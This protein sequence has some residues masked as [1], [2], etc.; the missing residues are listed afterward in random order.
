MYEINRK[1]LDT[2]KRKIFDNYE[3]MLK[4]RK[5]TIE[6]DNGGSHT[7]DIYK[8]EEVTIKAH[9]TGDGDEYW[10]ENQPLP[11][12]ANKELDCVFEEA[13]SYLRKEKEQDTLSKIKR[14]LGG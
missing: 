8:L 9:F 2:L 6:R 1:E 11:D 14:L 3:D 13:M 10:L 12:Y 4:T 7:V 5:Q